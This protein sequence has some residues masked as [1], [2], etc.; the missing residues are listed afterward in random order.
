[1]VNEQKTL[2]RPWIVRARAWVAIVL[3]SPFAVLAALSVP[4]IR[5]DTVADFVLGAA[6]WICFVMGATLRWWATLY[7]GGRKERELAVD[8]PYSICRNPLYLGSFLLTLSIAFFIH[9]LTFAVG[10]I[11]AMPLYLSV[12]VPWEEKRLLTKFGEEYEAY[13]QRV[14]K[15]VPTFAEFRSPKTLQVNLMP[16]LAEYRMALRWM[17]IPFLAEAMSYLRSEA[18]WPA[19]I[20]LP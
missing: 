8:G 14:P 9:S 20:S 7:V 6:G 1:M 12:T 17:W 15:F 16:L 3:I 19:L 5:E 13:R 11:I 2:K 18:W 4:V 10:L